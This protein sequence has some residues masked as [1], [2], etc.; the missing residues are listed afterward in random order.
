M[1]GGH[2]PLL[3]KGSGDELVACCLS[4]RRVALKRRAWSRGQEIGPRVWRSSD[5]QAHDVHVCAVGAVNTQDAL[6]RMKALGC[7]LW[8]AGTPTSAVWIATGPRGVSSGAGESR[9]LGDRKASIPTGWH[10][11]SSHPNERLQE[12]LEVVLSSLSWV[13]TSIGR[14]TGSPTPSRLSGL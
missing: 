3:C 2:G 14:A 13:V 7:E 5:R 6:P 8:L 10:L 11:A 12:L 1:L 4:L 9:S